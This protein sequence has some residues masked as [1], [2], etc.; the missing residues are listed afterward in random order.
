MLQTKSECRVAALPGGARELQASSGS[1]EALTN[2]GA[3][4]EAPRVPFAIIVVGQR[5]GERTH[6]LAYVSIHQH[7]SAYVSIRQH[8]SVYVSIR[9]HTSAII[10]VGQRVVEPLA[11]S[12]ALMLTYAH[13]CSRMLTY[14]HV[15]V[16]EPLANSLA[17]K[18]AIRD[19]LCPASLRVSAGGGGVSRS[20]GAA[21]A[22]KCGSRYAWLES[23]IAEEQGRMAEGPTDAEVSAADVC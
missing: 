8:T 19:A 16:G 17:L 3:V 21:R 13:V 6:T 4:I 23:E 5:V 11:N 2:S 18:H 14:A 9:Q 7:T 22:A 15:S 1:G 20:G 10:V 12:S